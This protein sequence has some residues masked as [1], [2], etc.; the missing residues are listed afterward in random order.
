MISWAWLG[1]RGVEIVEKT[2]TGIEQ[3]VATPWKPRDKATSKQACRKRYT[4]QA[5]VAQGFPSTSFLMLSIICI[6]SILALAFSSALL[7]S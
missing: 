6:S 1:E 3:E 7:A 5:E 4:V 2:G